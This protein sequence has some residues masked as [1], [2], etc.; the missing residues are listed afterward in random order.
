MSYSTLNTSVQ[1]TPIQTIKVRTHSPNLHDLPPLPIYTHRLI[2]RELRQ[3]DLEQY[4]TLLTDIGA[5]RGQNISN[6]LHYTQDVLPLPPFQD[7]IISGIFLRKKHNK[8]SPLIGDGGIYYLRI[9]TEWPNLTYR[10][11]EEHWNKGYDT[12]FLNAYMRYWWS[13]PRQ[14]KLLRINPATLNYQ[15][16]PEQSIKERVYISVTHENLANQRVLTKVGF[17]QFYGMSQ[18]VTH[19]RRICEWSLVGKLWHGKGWYT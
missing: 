12:E 3:T 18:A 15:D 10:I 1:P 2:L 17:E 13:I 4:H 16:N 19:W 6:G 14:T 11:K 9:D 5:M 7:E 8:E